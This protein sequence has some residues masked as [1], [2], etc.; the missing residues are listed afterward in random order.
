MKAPADVHAARILADDEKTVKIAI[1]GDRGIPARYSG[2]SNLAEEV[3]ARLVNDHGMDVTVYCR[4]HYFS[5]RPRTYRGAR[6]VYLPAPGGKSFESI[7]HSTAAILHA[8]CRRFDLAFVLD[9]GNAPLALPLVVRR[10]PVVFHTDGLGW[11]RRK[12]SP[13]QRRYYKWSERVCASLGSWLVTDSRAMQDYYRAEYGAESSFIPYGSAV[14]AA[15]NDQC[16]EK[17]GLESRRYL[18][19]VARIEP[20]NNTDL[21]IREYRASGLRRPLVIVGGARYETEYSRSVFAQA[22]DGV[23]CLGPVYE[24]DML[25]GLYRNCYLYVHGHEVG[26]TNP[27]LLRAMDAGAACL[28]I[29]VTFHREVLGD[30]VPHFDRTPGSLAALLVRLDQ[31]PQRVSALGR[32]ARDRAETLYRWDAVSAAFAELFRGLVQAR[33]ERRRFREAPGA[34]VY[35]PQEFGADGRA[36][37]APP[38]AP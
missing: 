10:M 19:V 16:L 37:A 23:R 36:L 11:Q 13:L 35:R 38:T 21:V 6:C 7:I 1:I 18:L 4:R 2:F 15:A 22:G 33:R 29:D 12:W 9:P 34:G 20:E 32:L 14:G 8:A 27:S 5:E 31:D 25:N 17:Y 28:P 26:G 30:D 3:S 24:P